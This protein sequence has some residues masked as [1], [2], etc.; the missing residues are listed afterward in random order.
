MQP[1][2]EKLS[3]YKGLLRKWQGAINLISNSTLDDIQTRHFEDSLQLLPLIADDVKTIVDLGSG[4]GFPALPIAMARPDMVVHCIESDRK[5]CT[6]LQNVSRETFCENVTIHCD[7][8]EAV[9]PTLSPDL[10]TARALAPLDQLLD[11]GGRTPALYL[12]GRQWEKEISEA[13]EKH[14]FTVQATPSQT[15]AEARILWITPLID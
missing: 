7:R 4:A 2:E 13:Q 11:W 10:L 12:K 3:I 14:R 1:L 6:F 9:L 8:I 15:D 5:K